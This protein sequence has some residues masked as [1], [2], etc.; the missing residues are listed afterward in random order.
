[1]VPEKNSFI[2]YQGNN[3]TMFSDERD[4][5]INLTEIANAWKGNRKK[6]KSWMKVKQTIDFLRVWE[7]KHNKNFRADRIDAIKERSNDVNTSLSIQYYI[8]ETGAIGIF[9]KHGPYGGTYAHRDIAIRFAGYL[10]P[11]FE[12]FLI[13]EVQ[14]L[15][16][17]EN[18]AQSGDRLSHKEILYLIQLKEIFKYVA[19]QEMIEG[20]HSEVYAA[21]RASKNPF[22]E[23][24]SY[25]NK[26]L[27]IERDVV[28]RRLLEYCQ[29]KNIALSRSLLKKS[30]RE[31]ILFFDTYEAVRNAVWDFLEIK[32]EVNALTLANLVRDII[33][34]EGGEVK[35]NNE[36]NLFDEKQDLG[37]FNDFAKQIGEIRQVKNAR[38]VLSYRQELKQLKSSS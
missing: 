34:T 7:Q 26:V 6:I 17:S 33:Q 24:H 14:R 4:D 11:E 38:E 16:S 25:R 5:Y 8:E 21:R 32:G 15:K 23:F 2:S 1:M 37:K 19:H 29:E 12:L 13:E 31:K 20:A 30:K 22:A 36:T 3:I 9:T 35:R 10:S 27:E 28:D 18:Q